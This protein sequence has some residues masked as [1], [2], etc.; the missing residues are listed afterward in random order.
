MKIFYYFTG[1]G[2]TLDVA[3]RIAE[4]VGGAKLVRIT[5]TTE[6]EKL[7]EYET[8]GIFTPVYMGS[9]PRLVKEFIQG[10]RI[11]KDKYIFTAVTCGGMEIATHSTLRKILAKKGNKVSASFTFNYPANNQTSYAPVSETQIQVMLQANEI[12][13]RSASKQIVE[14]KENGCHIN[15]AMELIAKATG[16]TM[17]AKNSDSNYVVSNA[18]NGCGICSRVCPALNIKMVEERPKW[19][20]S[21]ERC[22]ACMQLCPNRAI[23]FGNASKQW[24]RY[25]NPN[26]TVKEL[27]IR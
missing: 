12:E 24:G 26:I 14:R 21:C 9:A 1:T 6:Y 8:V 25:K 18:C 7:D 5:A 11:S 10:L 16:E 19:Q 23:E 20:H 22:T 4:E 3:Q 13:I 15:L 27:L 17:I 2:N